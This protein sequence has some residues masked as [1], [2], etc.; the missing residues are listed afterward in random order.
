MKSEAPR[1]AACTPA[2][3]SPLVELSNSIGWQHTLADWRTS[4][5]AGTVFGHRDADGR[6]LSSAA[7]YLYGSQLASI[8]QVIVRAEER[9]RGLGRAVFGKCLEHAQ[10]RPVILTATPDGLP[11]YASLGFRPVEDVIKL[12]APTAEKM[13]ASARCRAIEAADLA[14]VGGLDRAAMGADRE[15]LLRERWKQADR[16]ALLPDGAG[17]AWGTAQ[18]AML[19]IGPV[20]APD[21]EGALRLVTAVA[22][23][24]GGPL[25]ID[26]PARQA[27]FIRTL[28][29]EGF[30][31]RD[32]HPLMLRGARELPGD[33][34]RVFAVAT[35]A[36]G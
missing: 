33:R 29:A 6:I 17:F 20:I 31:H 23:G 22:N 35:L 11:L 18:R 25:R 24:H 4:L 15:V 10:D 19:V 32:T 30:E 36:F 9:R 28:R 1:L 13:P 34:G 3:A 8:G 2:D 16:G 26:V 5:A 14:S 12:I 27:E 21:D 7:I